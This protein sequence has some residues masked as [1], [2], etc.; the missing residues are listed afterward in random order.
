[1]PAPESRSLHFVLALG[2]AALAVSLS[3]C[4][5]KDSDVITIN[6]WHQMRPED[7]E[8]LARRL[9]IF[10]AQHAESVDGLPKIKVR[11][12]YKETE[13]LRSGLVSA[14]LAGKG[15]QIVY[16]PSDAAGLYFAMGAL[17]DMSEKFPDDELAKFDPKAVIR[18]PSREKPGH[19]D[20]MF[21]GDRFGNHLALI[22]NYRYIKSPPKDDRE[23][24]DLAVENTKDSTGD[25]IPDRYGLC[26]NY[27][28]PF[29]VVPFL[30]GFNGW[31]FD[32]PEHPLKPT[33]DTQ[34]AINAY[35]YVF[36][37]VNKYKVLPRSADYESAQ[38]LFTEGKVA[39]LIDGDWSWQG[40]L[41]AKAKDDEGQLILDARL[42][43]LPVV[44][45][46]GLPMASTV[47]PKGY[48][49]TRFCESDAE[50]DAAMEVIR[51]LTDK[52]T[53]QEYMKNKI[54]PSRL[55]L[56]DE[57]L[58]RDNSEMKV[59]LAQAERGRA[60]PITL[61]M[62]AV[63]D[64]MK[65]PYQLLIS[66]QMKPAAA[67]KRMQREALAR[68]ELITRASQPDRT[69]GL[70]YAG[71]LALVVYLLWSQRKNFT[72]FLADFQNQRLA[73]AL[74]LPAMALIFLTV[75][76]P[77][78]YNIYLSFSNMSLT[79]L[80]D[81]R[82]VGLRN[83]AEIAAGQTSQDFW[84]IFGKTIV[85]TV[86]NVFFHVTIGVALAVALNGPVRGKSIYRVLLIIPWAVPAFITALTWRGMFDFELGAVNQLIRSFGWLNNF[87]P[88]ALHIGPVNWLGEATPAFISCIIANV[89]LGFPF[90]MVIALGGLQGIPGELYEAA[91]IDRAS[92]W[93]QFKNITLPMLRPVLAP[94]ITLGAVWT[95]NNLNVVW[96]VSNR[97]DPADQTHILVSY[98]YKAAFDFY[99][100][101]YAA[102]LSMV[103]F[104]ILLVF[105]LVF[106]KK[107]RATEAVY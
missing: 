96:L 86:V 104:A 40:Y 98:V 105:S 21:I 9:D 26:W 22:Y 5:D 52:D 30:T 56:R 41:N 6:L 45:S 23:L 27:T 71:G 60:M 62:R 32:N 1:M 35:K 67:A 31:M 63:W 80:N 44:R 73:Y 79:N 10:N 66:G 59:S 93:Q 38:A 82:I 75:L 95:F 54:L 89:W 64:T 102:A 77:L 55:A 65:P 70:I 51:F 57:P 99:R 33:L 17:E 90:M 20:L 81:A 36:D 106:L 100:Y 101:G 103:I 18:L 37:L 91:R 83:Y 2:L 25:K 92:R 72:A 58:I 11:S 3:G 13:E 12:L 43:E 47:S 53:Q 28:E 16:G 69:V 97:G 87:L 49:L 76:Y 78:C 34:G 29:F 46:T 48:S 19:D 85:W 24:I 4:A 7:R 88:A 107:S 15:P 94:A 68:I 84:R 42:A 74:A 61:E 14:V 8:I 39:M 50:T